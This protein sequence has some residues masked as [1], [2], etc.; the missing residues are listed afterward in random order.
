MIAARYG[1]GT[2]ARAAGTFTPAVFTLL[3][4][5]AA[6]G[7]ADGHNEPGSPGPRYR[8][9]YVPA[10][11]LGELSKGMEP[12]AREE[13]ESLVRGV[14]PRWD[15]PNPVWINQ[16]TYR[17]EFDG[18]S[19][20]NGTISSF[21]ELRGDQAR[22]LELEP[23]NLDVSQL[24]WSS[25]ENQ[26]QDVDLRAEFPKASPPAVR[27]PV[28][29]Q[30]PLRDALWGVT[31]SGRKA[32]LVD[33]P[34]G[35]VVGKW[36][37]KGRRLAEGIE[38]ELQVPPASIC[39]FELLL[40]EDRTLRASVGEVL[41]PISSDRPSRKLWRLYLGHHTSS[42][43]I[44]SSVRPT[45]DVAPQ[46]AYENHVQ[47]IVGQD[48]VTLIQ[49]RIT[50]EIFAAPTDRLNLLLP[51]DVEIDAVN[52]GGGAAELPLSWTTE[53]RGSQQVLK[54]QL[55][56]PMIGPTRS[57]RIDAFAPARFEQKWS[58]PQVSLEGAVFLSGQYQLQIDRPLELRTFDEGRGYRS[59]AAVSSTAQSETFQFRQLKQDADITVEISRPRLAVSARVVSHLNIDAESWNLRSDVDWQTTSGSTFELQCSIPAGWEISSVAPRSEDSAIT[60]W[61][62][63]P[64]RDGSR[65]VNIE[66][67]KSVGP[68]EPKRVL[69][70]ASRVPLPA[71]VP[72]RL[73]TIE[74]L[75][76]NSVDQWLIVTH[77][78]GMSATIGTDSDFR[79]ISEDALP[80][81]FRNSPLWK[82]VQPNSE[83]GRMVLN[84]SGLVA[85]GTVTF[86]SRERALEARAGVRAEI[87]RDRL[88]EEIAVDLEPQG[89]AVDSIYLFLS[90]A[91]SQFEW[92]LQ[93]GTDTVPLDLL[94]MP[95]AQEARWNLPAGG[96]LWE[97]KLPEPQRA[98]FRV[99][100]RRSGALPASTSLP[101]VFVP[102]ARS[103]SGRI[104]WIAPDDMDIESEPT[105][106]RA[107]GRETANSSESK[108]PSFP[109]QSLRHAWTYRTPQD[110]LEMRIN[111]LPGNESRQRFASLRLRSRLSAPNSGQD[112]HLAE[113]FIDPDLQ[114]GGFRFRMPAEATLLGVRVN[115]QTARPIRQA[116]ELVIPSLPR[117]E[118][119]H[120][121]VE[122]RSESSTAWLFDTRR[123]P[124]V[125]SSHEI[126]RF[127]WEFELPPGHRLET[128]PAG[129]TLTEPLPSPPWTSRV[130]GAMA[131]PADVPVFNPLK[132]SSW[133]EFGFGGEASDTDDRKPAA[134]IVV[135]NS[136]NPPADLN[137]ATTK[138]S[139]LNS[140]HATAN[141]PP[142]VLEIVF[143]NKSQAR[144][145]AWTMLLGTL[146]LGLGFRLLYVLTTSQE[147]T[148][149]SR[150]SGA[151]LGSSVRSKRRWL[152]AWLG[153]VLGTTWVLP[154]VAAQAA[155]SVFL[156]TLLAMAVPSHWFVH[157]DLSAHRKQSTP[158]GSTATM[159][160][161][162]VSSLL[163]LAVALTAS[164]RAQ[165]PTVNSPAESTT[166]PIRSTSPPD[167]PGTYSILIPVDHNGRQE[168]SGESLVYAP[169]RLLDELRAAK[170]RQT[171][172]DHEY[173]I[174]SAEY[175]GVI[176]IR[177]S[178]SIEAR[179]RV[180]LIAP[181]GK[182][183][184][185]LPISNV[186]LDAPDACF[187]SGRPTPI[188]S[189]PDRSG[190]IVEIDRGAASEGRTSSPPIID[191]HVR[192][193]PIPLAMAGGGGFRVGIPATATGRIDLRFSDG[194]PP[195]QVSLGRVPMQRSG[196]HFVAKL[197]HSSELDV[198]WTSR[199][200]PDSSDLEARVVR[201]VSV[202]ATRLEVR[203][204]VGCRVTRGRVS[205][206]D[207]QM[208]RR[209]FVRNVGDGLAFQVLASRNS[210]QMSRL[211]VHF[212]EPR[213][214]D[215]V[216]DFS[217]MIPIDSADGEIRVPLADPF[218][219]DS[220][221][222]SPKLLVN[223]VGV[224]TGS[225]YRLIPNSHES[226][227]MPSLSADS[228]IK[229]ESLAI[230]LRDP[231]LAYRI[232][233]PTDLVLRLAP[234]LP[235]R[236]INV[237]TQEGTIGQSRLDWRFVA[238]I[239][240]ENAPAFGHRLTV[241]PRLKIESISVQ[242]D[243]AERRVRWA[244]DGERVNL[245]L[246]DRTTATQDLVL[247]GN[248]P[249][250]FSNEIALPVVQVNDAAVSQSR[251]VLRRDPRIA[252]ELG[253]IAGLEP[254]DT[255]NDARRPDTNVLVGQYVV[256]PGSELP[257]LRLV[258]RSERVRADTATVLSS[259]TSKAPT[260]TT[261]LRLHLSDR[262]IRP[263]R[264]RI[265]AVMG[266]RYHLNAPQM[267]TRTEN[268][269][270]GS[271][272]ISLEPV[273][274]SGD[275]VTVS[276][277]ASIPPPNNPANPWVL[278]RVVAA[279]I[280]DGEHFLIV[281]RDA[282]ASPADATA[283]SVAVAELPAWISGSGSLAGPLI[284][285]AFAVKGL[286]PARDWKIVRNQTNV[287]A[288]RLRIPFARM[289]IESASDGTE[290]GTTE[291][292]V[293]DASGREVRLNLP[294]EVA[295]RA[296]FVNGRPIS[297]EQS[298]T[299]SIPFDVG[300]RPQT[301]V[302]YWTRRPG[303]KQNRLTASFSAPELVPPAES[304]TCRI[305]APPRT[306]FWNVAPNLSSTATEQAAIAAEGLLQALSRNADDAASVDALWPSLVALRD[307]FQK[308]LDE[309]SSSNGTLLTAAE[310]RVRQ[311]IET[312]VVR[313][314]ELVP[315]VARTSAASAL[316]GEPAEMLAGSFRAPNAPSNRDV[317]YGTFVPAEATAS[318]AW[319][320]DEFW[321][322]AAAASAAFFAILLAG[323]IIV[324]RLSEAQLH[325]SAPLGWGA[326][327]FAWWIFLVPSIA[328]AAIL[329]AAGI[330]AYA[331]RSRAPRLGS[332]S[333][334]ESFTLSS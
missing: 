274:A 174:S 7:L 42:K 54:V 99:L 180:A 64:A 323:W 87:S 225:E 195:Q 230:G 163:I 82:E 300:T 62:V 327:G 288:G 41:G 63:K 151:L 260:F 11:K 113:F 210:G 310:G 102:G 146:L 73:A 56:E 121:E 52:Y 45:G 153:M 224:S 150:R 13:F 315:L 9:I 296:L 90:R 171:V 216:V 29:A 293:L 68:D 190:Y 109:A 207:F 92:T 21:V 49:A 249:L 53:Q 246:S 332:G 19:L 258:P 124:L 119:T 306:R 50:P 71:G 277:S 35:R 123:V 280:A 86:E 168:A 192:F 112:H 17:A 84:C 262:P 149:D 234:L 291:L 140:W 177:Q 331:I 10:E 145:L 242:E 97:L 15:E 269:E 175:R 120:V 330:A 305:V 134:E 250:S 165:E 188:L 320:F 24:A 231:E 31:E 89:E 117:R 194:A 76:C 138:H 33:R 57:I 235:L 128:E 325:A 157:W 135:E 160:R 170:T 103:F 147:L 237:Q 28:V 142:A 98:P 191:I 322:H 290:L 34:R 27:T 79:Q 182:A 316:R 252:V 6:T 115:G 2:V 47:C 107:D 20:R 214:Q 266:V 88:L 132:F 254:I 127:D 203:Y 32:L 30:K 267:T 55:P 318:Q 196:E 93:S 126:L 25:A 201:F 256:T 285:D 314:N 257:T 199:T 94:R 3:A 270:D 251:L 60:N 247:T 312:A 1:S 209:S 307:E 283:E 208:P 200:A 304:S 51:S 279:D 206:L 110:G 232:S 204:R 229:K 311:R 276:V 70:V 169:P 259:L 292:V 329:A 218:A 156:G 289:S 271:V 167:A 219:P 48:V 59:A 77:P 176:D 236:K 91:G 183:R 278:P 221:N 222:A 299:I 5:M 187:V 197:G 155:G 328:G 148:I 131:R 205:S 215:F 37:R 184:V 58:L 61:E 106:M 4:L 118:A 8:H 141:Q 173:L 282:G 217:L 298:S 239:R 226:D 308:L 264:L 295:P 67:L 69:V 287:A 38:F 333:D 281:E 78:R 193:Y 81:I 46:V 297:Q 139:S 43:V 16:S 116:E 96:E 114:P 324:N 228:P 44:V 83:L 179:Y 125:E 326:L 268:R 198:S 26:N 185:R 72:L 111:Q 186:N 65:I 74:P 202:F 66:F 317:L 36:E 301:A 164:S 108:S 220:P 189:A 248:M 302:F 181:S 104:E 130:F 240:T 100:G 105:G 284:W 213:E 101:L 178:A 243:G 294:P 162:S 166:R 80:Q 85:T 75:D 334:H 212:P 275:A 133:W 154:P 273:L 321:L 40:P 309:D 159:V 241:D 303:G 255:T 319:Q 245:F 137:N 22:L 211:R 272:E 18:E 244:R 233:S 143:C 227:R 39:M 136:D 122:Y 223:D 12:I 253:G 161:S 158:L 144:M 14:A 23:L 172:T 95:V 129:M 261:L 286:S 263:V 238:E 265:P 313:I 152:L